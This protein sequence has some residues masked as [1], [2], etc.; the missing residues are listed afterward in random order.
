MNG[1]NRSKTMTT[2]NLDLFRNMALALVATASVLSFTAVPAE[3]GEVREARIAVSA[4]ELSRP[5][6]REAVEGRIH[7]AARQVCAAGGVDW[8]N[9][10]ERVDYKLCFATAVRDGRAQMAAIASR[11]QLASR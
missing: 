7:A 4:Q 9:M 1:F 8:R 6:G 11:T 5:E 3:A 2:N 10:Q